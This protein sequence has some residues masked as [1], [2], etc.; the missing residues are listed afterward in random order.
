[1]PNL[2]PPEYERP[3]IKPWPPIADAGRQERSPEVPATVQM[4]AGYSAGDPDASDLR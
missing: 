3:I 1:M 4:D 2:P